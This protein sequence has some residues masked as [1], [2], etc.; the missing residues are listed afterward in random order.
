MIYTNSNNSMHYVIYNRYH[1]CI[2]SDMLPTSNQRLLCKSADTNT[3]F[4]ALS[5]LCSMLR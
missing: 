2:M 3:K 4:K 5:I 1:T